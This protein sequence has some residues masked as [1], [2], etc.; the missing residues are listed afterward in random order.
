M[1]GIILRAVTV[2]LGTIG[3]VVVGFALASVS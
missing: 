3:Y 1:K 2:L